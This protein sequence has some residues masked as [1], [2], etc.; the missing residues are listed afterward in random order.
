MLIHCPECR[1][2]TSDR[3]LMCPHC[4]FSVAPPRNGPG[5]LVIA[6]GV[7]LGLLVWSLIPFGLAF[8]F[9]GAVASAVSGR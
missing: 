1:E 5:T 4:G 3:A 8:L 2:R 9:F 7:F 6:S